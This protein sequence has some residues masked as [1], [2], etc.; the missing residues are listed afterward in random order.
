MLRPPA[1]RFTTL[2]RTG[3]A[4]PAGG[5]RILLHAGYRCARHNRE[6]GGAPHSEHLEGLAADVSVPGLSLQKMYEL[7]LEVPQFAE[8]GIG[9]YAGDF[10]HVDVRDGRARWARVAGRYVGIADLVKEAQLLAE[11]ESA[12]HPG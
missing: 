12:V 11:K 3:S 5:Q 6:V 1:D 2:G 7:A 4:A 10:V 8:R 9:V